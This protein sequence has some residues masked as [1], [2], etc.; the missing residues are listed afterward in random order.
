MMYR[1]PAHRRRYDNLPRFAIL[2]I[3]NAN[4]IQVKDEF[5]DTPLDVFIQIL[6]CSVEKNSRYV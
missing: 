3:R 5:G 2:P 6:Y 4:F 1:V